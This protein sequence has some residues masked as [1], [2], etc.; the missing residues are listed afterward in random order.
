MPTQAQIDKALKAGYSMEQ[1]NK[2]V[3]N[4]W[5]V[6]RTDAI[7]KASTITTTPTVTPSQ[8]NAPTTATYW[9]QNIL[10]PN[11][12]GFTKPVIATKDAPV[13][14]TPSAVG[15]L[16]ATFDL[17]TAKSYT[18]EQIRDK[19]YELGTKLQSEYTDDDRKWS[20]F[21][22]TK[23]N[24]EYGGDISKMIGAN[25]S[26]SSGTTTYSTELVQPW[27]NIASS[28]RNTDWTYKVT[29]KDGTTQTTTTEP[30]TTVF[31]EWT[32]EYYAQKNAEAGAKRIADLEAQMNTEAE[33]RKKETADLVA[34][35]GEN[36]ATQFQTQ[37]ADIEAN[38]AKRLEALN[39]T[40]SFSGFGRSSFWGEKR[41]EIAKNIEATINQ[42]KAK[43]DLE[44]M[45][46]RMERE[47]A[48]AEAIS[49]MRTNIAN[50]Q[51]NIDQANY[52]NQLE[53][54][55]LNQENATTG[56]E[57]MNNLL[58][59]IS[60][61]DEIA[62]NADIEKS[63]ALGYFVNKDGT[64]MLDSQK[65][66]I[67]FEGNSGDLDPTSIQA[68]ADAFNKGIIDETTLNKLS[69]ADRAAVM[70]NVSVNNWTWVGTGFNAWTGEMRTD[71]HNNPVAMTTDVAKTLGLVEGVDYTV[72]DPFTTWSG[73]VL[74]TARLNGDGLKTTIKA[75]DLA[76]N[77]PSKSAFM[78]QSGKPRWTYINMTD[79]EWL[80]KTPEE[81]AQVVATMYKNEGGNGS[82]N[83]GTFTI[84]A[85]GGGQTWLSDLAQ[86]VQKGIITIAQIPAAQRSQVAAEL[87]KAWESSPKSTELQNS[88][89]LI[90]DMLT[91]PEWLKSISWVWGGR[92][93]WSAIFWDQLRLNQFEQLKGIL[94]LWEREKLKGTGAISDFESK[95]L[96][97]SASA[98][99]R[100][101]SEPDFIKE[102]EKIR[103][104]LSGKYK[105]LTGDINALDTAQWGG[106]QSTWWVINWAPTWPVAPQWQI[107]T[108]LT[109]KIKEK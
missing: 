23:A 108:G 81:K 30:S 6:K 91:D 98:L 79:Q 85:T 4:P 82:I 37:K 12:T 71:R 51:A 100:N 84:G 45:A 15:T 61:G 34:K 78:T 18:S 76:A 10:S 49:A 88:I 40:L 103:D 75:L 5:S 31:P 96:A 63:Q 62:S 13:I 107:S 57:A 39:S 77:D 21:L 16:N 66:P 94:S 8:V 35:Y 24:L 20:N 67:Q 65:R 58:A 109:Y 60:N 7:P 68:Y 25:Q 38:G 29:Y 97:Q 72:G 46:Y 44:L 2:E 70:K 41:D 69:P 105:Y 104:I 32:P 95:M 47:G 64:L 3:A 53:I 89:A 48:D 50:V 73:K 99:G 27:E 36:I 19:Y 52:E 28:V 33:R 86:S 83:A 59:T 17:N 54:I 14:S 80:S 102:I 56:T 55:K 101:L 26:R 74:Y 9:E 87:S 11:V 1:I 92:I 90:D 106:V 42:A 43:A 93:P 22:K